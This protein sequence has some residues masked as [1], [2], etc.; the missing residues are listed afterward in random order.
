MIRRIRLV[1]L[2]TRPAVIALLALFGAT[3]L[4]TAGRATD[5]TLTVRVLA[6][7]LGFLLFSVV[8]NDLADEAVDRVNLPGQRPLA[9]GVVGRRQF[10]ILG[11]TSGIVAL[12]ASATLPWPAIVVTAAG[13]AISAGYSLRPVRLA[14]RGAVASLVLPACFV[15]VPYL[16]GIFATGATPRPGQ[17]GLLAGLYVGFIGRILLKDFRDV[18][19]DAL[20]GKRTFLVRHGRR[21][22]CAFSACCWLAGTIIMLAAVHRPTLILVAAEAGFLAGALV[23]LRALSMERGADMDGVRGRP[24]RWGAGRWGAGRWAVGRWAVARGGHRDEAL[25]TAIAIVGRG[26]ILLLLAHLSM[27]S[28]GWPAI[29]YDAVIGLLG[30]MIA[31]Q[32]TSMVRH[33][34]ITRRTIPFEHGFA[35][36][37]TAAIDRASATNRATTTDRATATNRASATNRATAT[38]RATA[39]GGSTL[40]AVQ[41]G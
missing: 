25:I 37:E 7:V 18:C 10:A 28:A 30:I 19:G 29:R 32:A 21:W 41:T 35:T 8:C 33:G 9:A 17:L 23:L 12:A 38:D 27:E 3:G 4:A 13:L 36:S 2:L 40:S 22:T 15:A 31:G 26:M 5:I 16:L 39:T 1:V 14:D 6:V 11:L 34:P 24:G 20:F